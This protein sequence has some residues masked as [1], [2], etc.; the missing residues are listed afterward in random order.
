MA[1]N[2]ELRADYMKTAEIEDL[3]RKTTKQEQEC[4]GY[5]WDMAI[6]EIKAKAKL[7]LSDK[8]YKKRMK[9]LR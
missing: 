3:A 4:I 8:D 7:L 6:K 5:G 2:K 9:V 1:S